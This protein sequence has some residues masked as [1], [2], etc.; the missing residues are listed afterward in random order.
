MAPA[1]SAVLAEVLSQPTAQDDL[2]AWRVLPGFQANR[3]TVPQ[4]GGV[5][6]SKSYPSLTQASGFTHVVRTPPQPS[7]SQQKSA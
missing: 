1:G 2:R 7:G 3:K 5:P 6:Q 4:A